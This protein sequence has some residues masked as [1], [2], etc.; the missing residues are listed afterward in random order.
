MTDSGRVTYCLQ[1]DFDSHQPIE[2]YSET[3]AREREIA[4]EQYTVAIFD[5]YPNVPDVVLEIF[6]Q[7]D[8]A[9][10]WFIDER[11]RQSLSYTFRKVDAGRLF[12][13]DMIEYS[14]PD[15]DAETLSGA[16]KVC[17]VSF[18]E[19]GMVSEIV[20]DHREHTKETIERGDVD[21]SIMWE[22]IPE[23]GNWSS[24]ARWD[25]SGV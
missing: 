25:R 24:L 23:F 6:W 9:G 14:Y 1:W 20:Y 16:W 15:V 18:S 11:G 19:D 12:L 10:V 7:N 17:F 21:V 5:N 4:G 2:L 3:V 13:G 22:A 8:H